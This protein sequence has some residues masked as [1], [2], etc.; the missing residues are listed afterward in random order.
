MTTRKRW[1]GAMALGALLASPSA[2][3]GASP[4]K[5]VGTWSFA[6]E[7]QAMASVGA[8]WFYTWSTSSSGNTVPA[9]VAFVPMIWGSTSVTTANLAQVK[10]EGS[11][12]LGFNEPDNSG[13]SNMTPQQALALWPQLVA[14]GMRLGSPAVAANAQVDGG[15]LDT[16][17]SGAAAQSLR[18]D[19]ITLH[20]YG[21]NF[22]PTSAVDELES[23]VEQTHAKYGLP[24]WVTEFALTNFGGG[25]VTYPTEAQQ[26]AFAA[27]AVNML[28]ATSYVERYAWFALP[29]CD[30]GTDSSSC[31][32]GNTRPL[33][34]TD[35]TLTS[36]GVAYAGAGPDGGL[37]GDAS[38]DGGA[39]ASSDG[40]ATG[41]GP[42]G[43]TD[44]TIGPW[45]GDAAVSATTLDDASP[46]EEGGLFADAST[47]PS[48]SLP[49]SSCR[50]D[51]AGR[52]DPKRSR[53]GAWALA[54]ATAGLAMRER[55]RRRGG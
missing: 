45:T 19:F 51:L 7:Q 13:Q 8:T 37:E 4:K 32:A 16:F 47:S 36:V 42:D 5:G 1:L 20:W 38:G 52:A 22:D 49:N 43:S 41:T 26:A 33:S 11:V 2:W 3:A 9:G 31:A 25:A 34:L 28:E 24:I 18:V 23:Y 46:F 30:T 35:G 27:G 44:A 6:G 50:C 39:A 48:P 17:L 29:P 54:L 53:G 15:W 12:L 55:R 21:G 14:T 10:T 40:S